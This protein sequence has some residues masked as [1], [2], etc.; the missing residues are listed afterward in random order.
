MGLG[1]NHLLRNGIEPFQTH[2]TIRTIEPFER[3]TEP[4]E[5][6]LSMSSLGDRDPLFDI[7]GPRVSTEA[8][9]R[10]GGWTSDP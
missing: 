7:R 5:R 6:F 10:G 1:S 3:T 4:F 8:P 2:R 9:P